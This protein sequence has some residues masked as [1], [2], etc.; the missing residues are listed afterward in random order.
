M[1]NYD[2]FHREFLIKTQDEAF[3]RNI[4]TFML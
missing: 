3:T 1:L 2:E 4:V